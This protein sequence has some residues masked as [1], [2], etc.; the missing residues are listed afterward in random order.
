MRL[1]RPGRKVFLSG[2]VRRFFE[3]LWQPTA[4]SDSGVSGDYELLVAIGLVLTLRQQISD[5]R[6]HLESKSDGLHINLLSPQERINDLR[7][8]KVRC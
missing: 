2:L 5:R 1:V 6:V 4:D 3:R 7:Q 8:T